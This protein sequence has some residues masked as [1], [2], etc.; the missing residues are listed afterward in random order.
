MDT[1]A[2]GTPDRN[3]AGPDPILILGI[4]ERSG[5]N[6]LFHLLCLHPECDGGGPLW[7][8][9]LTLHLEQLVRF[10]EDVYGD[11]NVAWQVAESIGTAET[12]LDDLGGGLVRYLNRQLHEPRYSP[13]G[14]VRRLVAKT[15]SVRNLEH[16]RRV[17]PRSPL[18]VLV[19]DGRAVV[20]SGHRSFDIGY[21]AGMRRWAAS[22]R[23]ILEWLDRGPG[24]VAGVASGEQPRGLLVRY[25]DLFRN[26]E[27]ELRR[28]F[29]YL[30]IDPDAYDYAA[31]ADLPVVGSS[32][33]RARQGRLH[34]EGESKRAGFDPTRRSSGWSKAR[35]H[36][37]AWLAGREAERLGYTVE[38]PT[39]LRWL[40]RPWQHGL[41]LLWYVP[42]PR[43]VAS[44]LRRLVDQRISRLRGATGG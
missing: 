4:S 18:L 26:T 21:E 30:G 44:R 42:G 19:R 29:G 37:F 14:C 41:D 20:E 33:V 38:R 22:A 8:N 1:R 23:A 28:I 36:R 16:V 25:E 34:W 27:R 6:F 39:R 31:A 40:N 10:A 15:P 32:D 43:G 17:F 2:S 24:G 5:T 7:E 13:H 35:E 12:L 11:W 3:D 9:Y